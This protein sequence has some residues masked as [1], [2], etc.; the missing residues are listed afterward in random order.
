MTTTETCEVTNRCDYPYCVDCEY[1]TTCNDYTEDTSEIQ[2][3]GM[4]M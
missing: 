3:L 2:H 1:K 4:F